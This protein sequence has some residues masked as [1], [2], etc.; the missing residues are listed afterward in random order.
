M[1]NSK[2]YKMDI[3]LLDQE[4]WAAFKDLRLEALRNHPEAFGSSFEEESE[5]TEAEWRAGFNTCHMFGCFADNRLVASAGYFIYS[6]LKMRHRA[7]LF[8]MYIKPDNRKRGIADALVKAVIAHARKR[9]TQLHLTVV[10]TNQ[11]AL[12]LYQKNGFKI[13]G[14]EPKALK[15]GDQTYD[16]HMMVLEFWADWQKSTM[17]SCR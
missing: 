4:D 13:Y 2:H 6:S 7:V 14:T 8:A 17:H 16:E 1:H 10:T 12:K 3:R 15:I 5:R 9:V 11:T